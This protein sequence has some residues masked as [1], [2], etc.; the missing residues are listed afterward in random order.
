MRL[1]AV[2]ALLGFAAIAPAPALAQEAGA[3]RESAEVTLVEAPVRVIDRDGQPVRDLTEANFTVFDDGRAQTI[4]G[5]DAIDLAEKVPG[6][7]ALPVH[8][9]AR[10]RFLILF[11]FSFSRPRAIVNARKAARD[12]VLSG[13]GEHDLAAVATYSVERGVQLLVTFSSDRAQLARAIESLGLESRQEPSDPLAF[14]FDPSSF[15]AMAAARPGSRA[16]TEGL[17]EAL[18][19]FSALNKARSDEYA[20]GRVR[21][22]FQAFRDLAQALDAVEGRKDIVYL[23]EGFSARYLVGVRE[24][25]EEQGYLL[26]GE[27][28]KVDSEKR[29]GSTPLRNELNDVGDWFRRSDCVVHA[30]DIAGIRA[31]SDLQSDPASVGPR[32]TENSLY[33]IAQ[34][35]GGEVLRN[36]NDL[37]AQLDRLAQQ[38]SLVYVLAFRP[39][40]PGPEGKFHTLKVKVSAPGARVLARAGYYE[41]RSFRTLSPL[42]RSL[43]AAN[44]IAN[45]IALGDIPI[46]VLA[47]PLASGQESSVP[48]LLEIPGPPLLAMDK[49]EKLAVEVYVYATGEDDRLRDFFVRTISADLAKSREKLMTAG[50]RY[51]G[52]LRLAPGKYRIRALVRNAGTGRMGFSVTALTV[53]PFASG[54]PYL[55]PPLFLEGPGNW[56]AVQ[57]AGRESVVSPAANPFATLPGD[58]LT[59]APMARVAPG[60]ASRVCI[61]AYH[62]GAPDARDLKLG[63]QIL[64]EDGRP[65]ETV[66]LAVLGAVAPDPEGKRMLLLSFAAPAGLAPGRY[67]LRVF[68]QDGVGGP[69]RQATTP[70]LVP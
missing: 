8:P 25:E 14:A 13:M 37:G 22:L 33:E 4:V 7:Q 20:R 3:V 28:W 21:H 64:A 12:F 58:G 44:V 34:V 10:R 38:T 43:L 1:L 48:V 30:V 57:G 63:S 68:L 26:H 31:E 2:L 29:F 60:G 5:F 36:T 6:G 51:Y 67:G 69:A 18:Q 50:V 9:A 56:V 15:A 17:I 42:E 65:L 61:I 32:E 59:P 24:T 23:S 49:G 35:T 16:G 39:D 55:L 46:H 19:T 54:E 27:M 47:V 41:R 40:R 66:K 52:E 70:F 62:L 11:D 45:E 53:P